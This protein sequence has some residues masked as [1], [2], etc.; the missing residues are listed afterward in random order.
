MNLDAVRDLFL[1]PKVDEIQI[2]TPNNIYVRY[3]GEDRLTTTV[4]DPGR[5][6]AACT[7]I[8]SLNDKTIAPNITS[9]QEEMAKK[10]L[11]A[12]LPGVRIE[13]TLPP[14]A[15]RG[16]AMMIRK[17]NPKRVTLE[18][19]VTQGVMTMGQAQTIKKIA[20]S[21]ETFI[22]SGPTYSGKTTLLNTVIDAIP[23]SRR[24][25][26]I[27]Q[28][29]ELL[30]DEER[31]FVRMEVDP[32]HGV[33]PAA[34]LRTAMRFSPHNII[35]G[36]LRG[37]EAITYLD[38]ANT[39]HPGATTLHANSHFDALGRLEDMCI[40]AG[41]NIPLEG[42]R[43]KIARA[44]NWVIHVQYMEG[45]GRRITGICKVVGRTEDLKDYVYEDYTNR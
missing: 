13:V 10:I 40:Q 21:G 17:H 31:N 6:E 35:S 22:I 37:P 41:R 5:F 25:F 27:E 23:H 9:S 42:I 36:E 20:E 38:A 7:L 45:I 24:L 2:N 11:S 28:V 39:G 43:A 12:K 8:A 18:E 4:V 1:D 26:V 44:I 3:E 34:A 29:S 19:Y 32:D 33:T 30:I 16:I 14:V 15:V